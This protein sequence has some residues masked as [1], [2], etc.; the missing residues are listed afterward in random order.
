MKHL[1]EYIMERRA[2]PV[3]PVN[4]LKDVWGKMKEKL[5]KD[6]DDDLLNA[7]DQTALNDVLWKLENKYGL[8]LM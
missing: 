2:M 5:G 6:F 3:L 8:G 4:K 7:M 1:E